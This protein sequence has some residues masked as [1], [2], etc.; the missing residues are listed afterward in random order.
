MHEHP[1]SRSRTRLG[2]TVTSPFLRRLV[3]LPRAAKR[4]IMV[5]ADLILVPLA[6]WLAFCLRL[7][8]LYVPQ[9][10][11]RWV[12][13]AAP[14][15]SIPTFAF[16]RIYRA[17]VHYMGF[18]AI[19]RVVQ[20]AAL[21]VLVWAS[22]VML[23]GIRGV[24][25]SVLLIYGFTSLA[26]VGGS[27]MFVRWLISSDVLS[28]QRGQRVAIYGCGS[29]GVQLA[30]A[31]QH[32]REMTAVAFIDDNP[33]LQGIEVGGLQTCAVDDLEPLIRR[34]RIRQVLLAIPSASRSRKSEILRR[35][36]PFPV[37][38]LIV[39]SVG[40]LA[41]GRVTVEDLRYVDIDDLL[42]RAAV[43]SDD[44]LVRAHATGKSVLVTGA[45]GTI[46]SELC[47]QVLRLEPKRLVLLERSEEALY[48]I[49]RE[50]AQDSAHLSKNLVTSV[51]GS[52]QHRE[53]VER[54]CDQ[55]GID[56]I[57]HAAAYK[58]V[59]IL[60]Q[61]PH[62]AVFNNV[63]GTFN[64]VAAAVANSVECFV[65]VSTDK[66]V[67]PTNVMGATKRFAEF[68][69]QGFAQLIAGEATLSSDSEAVRDLEDAL[70]SD[71]GETKLCMVRFGNVL[72]SSGSVIPRFREQIRSGGPVTVTH[73]DVIRYFMTIP[74]A[75]ELVLQASAIADGGDV[76][77]LD[78]GDPVRVLDLARRMIRL[79]G[80]EVRDAEHPDGDIE[81]AFTGLRPGE[82][83]YEELL[84]GD[85]VSPTRHPRIRRASED[86]PGFDSVCELY[87][88]LLRAARAQR[89]D[90][91][92][93]ALRGAIPEYVPSEHGSAVDAESLDNGSWW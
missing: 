15:V 47:R 18:T 29:A 41:D 19:W 81:I 67:R 22:V 83:L 64:A 82:K 63:K 28:E 13:V 75:A 9:G 77:V 7:G 61:N 33:K 92:V 76:L 20:A 91:V 69:A 56:T 17:V 86:F 70:P 1:R 85:N 55:H 5:A 68:I 80:L 89:H 39:P 62:E 53:T 57:L 73:P 10:Q 84:I 79:S 38:V 31:L 59:P 24:P 66:A 46:G 30:A 54:L 60:E 43:R 51:L 11:I 52:V 71:L 50:L 44:G 16:F 36:E 4:A 65:L 34:Q 58:H 32:S 72:G 88:Q 87:L 37:E 42:E 12:F 26:F 23:S 21:S 25:R 6:L 48:G 27:R 14:I 90:L 78:M 74:E 2:A 3:G 8:E 49:H 45:G 93:D 40:E 35:L